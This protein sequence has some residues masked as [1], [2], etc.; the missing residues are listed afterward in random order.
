MKVDL[1]IIMAHPD[2]AELSCSGTIISSI[3]SGMKVGMI[4]LTKGEMGTRGNSAIR[5]EEATNSA[6]FMKVEFRDNLNF[7]DVFFKNNN[8]NKKLLIK[9]IRKYRP[10]IIITNSLKDRHPDH[11]KASKMVYES[12]FI[13][14]LSKYKTK[15]NGID[16]NKWSPE[17]ILYSIQDKYLDPDFIVDISPFF[18]EKI[19]S[20]SFFKSQFYNSKIKEPN[21]YISSK[22]F[23]KFIKARSIEL[24]HSIGV[25][26]GEGYLSSKKI[27]IKNLLQII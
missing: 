17:L 10:K 23:M 13:S 4:D 2:D 15:Y 5:I 6:R 22:H 1:L 14:G 27:G 9:E 16:Q 21:T 18:K 24:G 12:C 19:K 25:D 11:E 7:K 8:K 3:N 20:I 26:H